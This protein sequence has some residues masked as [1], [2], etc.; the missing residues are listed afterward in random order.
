MCSVLLM[1]I[2]MDIWASRNSE[3]CVCVLLFFTWSLTVLWLP[4]LCFYSFLF[5]S[6]YYFHMLFSVLRM[7]Y[8]IL[9]SAPSP[10]VT[11]R[12]FLSLHVVSPAYTLWGNIHLTSLVYWVMV[13]RNFSLNKNQV[14]ATLPIILSWNVNAHFV[15]QAGFCLCSHCESLTLHGL[16]SSDVCQQ[17]LRTGTDLVC[18]YV[19]SMFL[20]RHF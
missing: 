19:H 18:Q 20:N 16:F 12:V 5:W 1:A 3:C 17:T 11:M 15:L 2:K 4:L 6:S 9:P 10:A 14:T 7:A 8:V 13:N